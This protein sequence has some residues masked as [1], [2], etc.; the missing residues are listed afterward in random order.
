MT[1]KRSY[2]FFIIF[3]L[4]IYGFA[5]QSSEA[6]NKEAPIPEIN[7]SGQKATLFLIR[8]DSMINNYTSAVR[9]CGKEDY[10]EL[11]RGQSASVDVP[12]GKCPISMVY[13]KW[14]GGTY[15][16]EINAVAGKVHK[17]RISP[18]ASYVGVSMF[19]L[20]G[21]LI[22]GQTNQGKSGPFELNEEK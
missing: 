18:R 22:E 16:I 14:Q 12:A 1:T 6:S 15:A 8:D 11:S 21:N 10:I 9:V 13:S 3:F 7:N 19:G 4:L 2:C 5:A 17:I 20:I